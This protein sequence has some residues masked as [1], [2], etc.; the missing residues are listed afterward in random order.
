MNINSIKLF[1]VAFVAILA[2]SC[3]SNSAGSSFKMEGKLDGAAELRIFLEEVLDIKTVQAI[4]ETTADKDGNFTLTTDEKPAEGIY[5][6]RA[7]ARYGF[8]IFDGKESKVTLNGELANLGKN[9]FE[10]TGSSP[11]A[12]LVTAANKLFSG[13]VT[14]KN[15]MEVINNTSNPLVS[16]QLANMVLQG[17]V[18][19]AETYK[20][21]TERVAKE[22]PDLPYTASMQKQSQSML[23]QLAAKK[24]NEKIK[25][26]AMAPDIALPNPDGK[27]MKLSDLKGK[28]VLLDFWAAWCRPCRRENPNVVANYNKYNKKGFEVFSVSLDKTKGAWTKAIEQDKL[29]WDTHVSD[30]KYWQSQAAKMYGVKSIPRAFLI[31]RDGKI[32]ATNLRGHELEKELKKVL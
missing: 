22:Y 9:N 13:S 30:L 23:A 32:V 31:D 28:V 2:V 24:A 25:I 14:S 4:A 26:G 15:L 16:A 8:L 29:A 17:N 1:L 3:G 11:S 21:I 20:S 27:T 10:V 18:D 6:L 5:R 12:E 7:G 19:F